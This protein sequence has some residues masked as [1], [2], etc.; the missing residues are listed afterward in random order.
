MSATGRLWAEDAPLLDGSARFA[1]D[2]DPGELG[3][4]EALHVAFVR[5]TVAHAELRSIDVRGAR[6]MPGVVAAFTGADLGL[7]RFPSSPGWPAAFARP[8]LPTDR[9]RYVGE[10]L[11]MVIAT[12]AYLAADAVEAVVV[13][14]DPLPPVVDLRAAAR[15]DAPLVHPDAGSNIVATT[16]NEPAGDPLAG[17]AVVVRRRYRNLRLSPLPL[18]TSAIV[19][20]AAADG[21][22]DV[23][24][25][26]QGIHA[27]R[28]DLAN[29]LGLEPST[30][31][32]R[33]SRVGGG[34]GARYRPPIEYL[35]TTAAARLTDRT[36][37]WTESRTEQL[38]AQNAGRGHDYDVEL[39]LRADGTLTGWR[40]R[41]VADL[42][43]YPV[44]V[45]PT[46]TEYSRKMAAGPYRMPSVD[47]RVDNVVTTTTPVS[48]YRGAGQ[49]EVVVALERALDEG[50]RQLGLDP[51][52]V[53]RRNLLRPDELPHTAPTGVTY[54]GGD[55]PAALEQALALA[56]VE[57]IR[58][59]QA[60]TPAD[61]RHRV[62][63]G[64]CSYVQIASVG[65]LMFRG[66]VQVAPDGTI[67]A[68]AGG[69]DHGQGHRSTI[70]TLVAARLGVAPDA[71]AW[72]DNDT[73][74]VTAG[75]GTGGSRTAALAGVAVTQAATRL[76]ERARAIAAELLEADPADI[77]VMDGGLG[78]IGV[79]TSTKTW[80]ELATFADPANGLSEVL[81]T[82]PQDANLPYGAHASVV[83]VDVDTG[84]VRV[85]RH[86]AVDDCGLRLNETVVEGQQHGGAVAG[87]SQA[88][89]EALLY[90]DDG[91]PRTP[92]LVEYYLPAASEVPS[93]TTGAPQIAAT[94]NELGIR[95]IGEN[96]C[97]AA[98]PAVLNA[99]AD[100][101]GIDH[102]DLPLTPE[103]VWRYARGDQP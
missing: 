26:N 61:A 15:P 22:L 19:V 72:V 48:A 99:V 41:G 59:Q 44:Q 18:E 58:A 37:R 68:G 30:I 84:F 83:E 10:P 49:P 57:E 38:L 71:V 4:G 62:G 40:V 25:A 100:A 17:A 102:I 50:A 21:R 2:L 75:H 76:L 103:R 1:A 29:A 8:I 53:R 23:W 87:L 52:E 67:T 28:T 95:G 32:V 5:S 92:T 69:H 51:A 24:C 39:G 43:A 74:I 93:I 16:V 85:L 45:P 27:V 42:G 9:T 86:V 7:A 63:I 70:A 90:D 80:A 36:L 96:G 65:K 12:D 6:T 77:V 66:Q 33:S 35:A 56:G 88:F 79:P 60:A 13:D 34:F 98:P 11:A 73:D 31:R 97:I 81:D 82:E 55:Y 94:T 47:F 91:T 3:L 14:V 89:G 78:V 54:D 20:G 64:V 101:L 46:L